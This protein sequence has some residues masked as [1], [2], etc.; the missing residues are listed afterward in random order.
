MTIKTRYYGAEIIYQSGGGG[1][2]GGIHTYE[3]LNFWQY[4][5]D[6]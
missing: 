5:M 2:G 4:F 3:R 6:L 1:G